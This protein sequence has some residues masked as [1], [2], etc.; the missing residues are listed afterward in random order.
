VSDAKTERPAVARR[1]RSAAA[2]HAERIKQTEREA[3]IVNLLN[4][5][6]S[7]SEIAAREGVTERHMRRLIETILKKRMPAAPAQFVAIQV[8]RLHE[9]LLVSYSAMSGANLK[10]VDR[11]VRIVRELDR[12]HGFETSAPSAKPKPRRLAPQ[13]PLALAG[14]ESGRTQMAPQAI[15][16][17]R[18]ADANGIIQPHLVDDEAAANS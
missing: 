6:A 5:G 14:P 13:R 15:E 1:D 11:V 17:S 16:K 12:Y 3:R 2:R 9:A 18:F 10:A 4:G 8:S 7:V